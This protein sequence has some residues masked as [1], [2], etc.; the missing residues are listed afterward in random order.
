MSLA[1]AGCRHAAAPAANVVTIHVADWGGASA[2]EK[3]NQ[4]NQQL[5]A[6]FQRLHPRI[7]LQMEHMPDA[8]T[9]KVMMTI[10]AG[11]QPDVIA[12]DASYAAI[13]IDNNTLQDLTPFIEGDPEMRLSSFYPNVVNVA[14]RGKAL[15]A[16]PA[17]FTPMMMYYNKASFRRA[18]VPF[19]KEGWTWADF[20][21]AARRL[22]IRRNGKVVQYGF[23]ATDWM[24]GWVM[25]IWQNGGSVLSPD[26][27]KATG[28]L[29]SKASVEAMRFYTDLVVKER[30]APTTSEAQAMGTSNFQAGNV[31]MDVSGHW[32][33]P[34]YSQNELYPLSNVG[35]V[36]LPRNKAHVTVMY[37]SGPAM[38]RGCKH[39]KEAWEY[40]KFIS[41]KYAQ[42]MYADQGIA[43]AADRQIAEEYR[44]KSPLEPAF[45]DNVRY[46][47]GPTGASV[48]Q[49]ALV[50]DIGREAIDEILL[51]KR[52]VEAALTEAAR[53]IDVQLG[54]E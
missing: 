35:V 26:G 33:I 27:K 28:Y 1:A 48:E 22:T 2:D 16:M 6:E 41:G 52:T 18:G 51:K 42:R 54:E 20:H 12:L 25:W 19:P 39:P 36:G 40:I 21:D 24:P 29:N 3:S 11:T 46:A 37:E 30:L 44:G 8:Y 23:N 53:R 10:L 47:R 32:M 5:I 50:E 9:Q 14:R 31:A 38:M 15:Y 17:N 45:L 34:T 49:Y 4:Q 7:R 13:F 43:I